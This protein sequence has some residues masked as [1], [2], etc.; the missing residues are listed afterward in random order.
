VSVRLPIGSRKRCALAKESFATSSPRQ[1][2]WAR[3]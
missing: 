3:W 1:A 2:R